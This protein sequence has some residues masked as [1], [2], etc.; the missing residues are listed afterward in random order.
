MT[1][2]SAICL[3]RFRQVLFVTAMGVWPGLS[4]APLR[5]ETHSSP[6]STNTASR[7]LDYWVGEW[8]VTAPGGT[9][10]STSTVSLSL[11]QCLVVEHW[12]DGKGHKGENVFGY[13]EDDQSW[14][15]LFADNRGRVHVFVDG[16]VVAD[17]AEFRGSS[18]GPNGAT[19]LNRVRVVRTTPNTIEQTWEKSTDNGATWTTVFRGQYTR[20]NA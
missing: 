12:D 19:V 4:A 15:G 20:R 17:A 14:R 16:R 18:G 2:K 7:Q 8:V 1:R 6:C 9:G 3:S 10:S 11:D 5:A 13:S